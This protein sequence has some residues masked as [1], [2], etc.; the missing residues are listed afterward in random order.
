MV[1][2]N[3]ELVPV[4]SKSSALLLGIA[5]VGVVLAVQIV[6][7]LIVN[8]YLATWEVRGQFGDLFGFS[9]ALFSGLGLGGIV[10]TLLLQVRQAEMQ[11]AELRLARG[12]AARLLIKD[13]E[14]QVRVSEELDA[15]RRGNALTSITFL[16]S[17][18]EKRAAL[19]RQQENS[20]RV[21]AAVHDEETVVAARL[22]DLRGKLD[23][24]YAEAIA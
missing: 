18:Y 11:G 1:T 22:N 14:Q 19:L 7:L 12:E 17:Y 20:G 3:T 16:I 15:I 9:N 10:Y 6:S 8:H 13:T 23:S 2:N 4:I 21:T 24:L 5:A